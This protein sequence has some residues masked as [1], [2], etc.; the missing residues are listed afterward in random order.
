MHLIRLLIQGIGILKKHS[1]A[2]SV[3]EH[4]ESL[5]EI[6]DQRRSWSEVNQWR[7]ALHREFDEA[8]RSTK[9]PEAPDYAQADRILIS[10]RRKMAEVKHDS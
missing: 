7:I 4:R 1:L 10:A 6:R 3:S 2:V 9:L 5:L 8:F